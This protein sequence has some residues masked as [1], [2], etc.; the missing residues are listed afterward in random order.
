MTESWVPG[1]YR[2]RI[3]PL[4]LGYRE[5]GKLCLQ[6]VTIECFQMSHSNGIGPFVYACGDLE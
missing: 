3:V 1:S 6:A 5:R 2:G 4:T